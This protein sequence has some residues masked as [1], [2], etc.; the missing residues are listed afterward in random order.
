MRDI[1]ATA[2]PF[3]SSELFLIFRNS[4]IEICQNGVLDFTVLSAIFQTETTTHLYISLIKLG[5][6]IS[7]SHVFV[8]T[9]Q[10]YDLFES[11]KKQEA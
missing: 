8:N 11:V 10:N 6:K 9:I 4:N 7:R 5:W 2:G 1:I 3:Q